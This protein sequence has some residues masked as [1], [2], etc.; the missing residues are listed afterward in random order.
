MPVA[1]F[2]TG[3]RGSAMPM[4]PYASDE[5][6]GRPVSAR[7]GSVKNNDPN[8]IEPITSAQSY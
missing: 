7:V 2:G 8:L 6:I 5:M 3:S 1:R 4:V